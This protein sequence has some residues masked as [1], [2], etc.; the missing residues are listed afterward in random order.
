LFASTGTSITTPRTSGTICTT[1][2]YIRPSWLTGWNTDRATNRR[3]IPP[4][5]RKIAVQTVYVVT[6]ITLYLTNSSHRRRA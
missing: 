1:G 3:N 2:A 6:G 5:P 4:A